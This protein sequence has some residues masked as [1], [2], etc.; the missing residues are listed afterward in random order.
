MPRKPHETLRQHLGSRT[1]K[2]LID[3][4]KSV[5][6]NLTKAQKKTPSQRKS[7]AMKKRLS[8]GTVEIKDLP[9]D[10]FECKKYPCG[11][12]IAQCEE[13]SIVHRCL[14]CGVKVRHRNEPGKVWEYCP[15]CRSGTK[16]TEPN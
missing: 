15:V 9:E 14:K 1:K 2:A 11:K 4:G 3:L 8:R 10:C 16:Q 7:E 12:K 13:P 5:L 6:G